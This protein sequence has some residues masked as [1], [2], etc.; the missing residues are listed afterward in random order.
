MDSLAQKINSSIQQ[1]TTELK[2]SSLTY[3]ESDASEFVENRLDPTQGKV[4]GE[5]RGFKI[6]RNDGSKGL[7]MSYSAHPTNIS[8]L[9]LEL[10]G[11]YPNAL[12]KKAES[13]NYDFAMFAS[14]TVG[15]HRV[16][17]LKE[18]QFELCDSLASRLFK[19][20][21]ASNNFKLTDSLPIATAI[22]PVHYG[23]SQ[24]HVLQNFKARDWV[25]QWLF[26]PLHGDIT[27]VKIGN[28]LMLGM[29]CD[30]SGEIFTRDEL[31][32]I[33]DARKEKLIITSFNGDYV[34]YIT[35]D[36]HYGHSEQE[37]V[38]AMNWVGPYYGQYF[39]EV[40]RGILSKEK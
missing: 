9:S 26:T 33:A 5:I 39:S 11:D 35:Y 38:M 18:T 28:V 2:P 8:H 16:K 3:F 27:Y 29:P 32:K 40:V 13:K 1:L 17:T 22:F 23:P 19:K 12:I 36:D 24:L 34:G 14:S 4:D 6:I 10:S 20:I 7:W 37:E 30:F 15:S 25:F 31:G 21:E